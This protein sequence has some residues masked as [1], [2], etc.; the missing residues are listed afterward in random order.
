M[1]LP[2]SAKPAT[3]SGPLWCVTTEMDSELARPLSDIVKL[4]QA[5]W[6]PKVRRSAVEDHTDGVDAPGPRVAPRLR[7]GARDQRVISQIPASTSRRRAD[8]SAGSGAAER[9][10]GCERRKRL[11][12]LRYSR[13]QHRGRSGDFGKSTIGGAVD[14]IRLS[15]TLICRVWHASVM[16]TVGLRRPDAVHPTGNP[17]LLA[18]LADTRTTEAV[19]HERLAVCLFQGPQPMSG[20]I[21]EL[22]RDCRSR[23]AG[24]ASSFGPWFT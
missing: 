11:I 16:P 18:G 3:A 5:R 20:I 7:Q 15:A 23:T 6:W 8:T 9:A 1:S 17:L 21:L 12:A 2:L 4:Q 24:R 19:G 22:G 13:R 10:G 14:S